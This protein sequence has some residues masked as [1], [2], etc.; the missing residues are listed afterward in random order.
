MKCCALN[1][2]GLPCNAYAIGGSEKCYLHS[3]KAKAR[4][5]GR[6]GGL[7]Q[8]L[9]KRLKNLPAPKT[10]KEFTLLLSQ[11]VCELRAGKCDARTANAVAV[12]GA[13]FLKGLDASDTAERLDRLE[14][15]Y[16]A[17]EKEGK[18][19]YVGKR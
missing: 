15:T 16:A 18:V 14:S 6:A 5:A 19:V 3:S 9:V 7:R 10:A 2:L 11:T 17:I 8:G 1:R 13:T 4:R 12:L